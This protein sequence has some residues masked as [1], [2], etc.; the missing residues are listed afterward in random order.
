MKLKIILIVIIGLLIL[1]GFAHKGEKHAISDSQQMRDVI[2]TCLSQSEERETCYIKVCKN[3]S[4]LCAEEILDAIV[5]INGPEKAIVVLQDIMASSLFE[6]KTD[7]HQLAHTIG[8]SASHH[9][10]A[11][12]KS[13]LRC[14][15]DFNYGCQHGFFEK[16]LAKHNEPAKAAES[17]C[18]SLP[19]TPLKDRFYCYHGVG[20]GYMFYVSYN[21][22]KALNLCDTLST[23]T[24]QEGCWQGVFMENVNGKFSGESDALLGFKK[25]DPLAPCNTVDTKYRQQCYEN[26][27]GYLIDYFN[28]SLENATNACLNAGDHTTFCI[29]SIGLMTTNPGWQKVLRGSFEGNFIETAVHICDRFPSEYIQECYWAAVANLANF[30]TLNLERSSEFCTAINMTSECFK[31]VGANVGNLVTDYDEYEKVCNI[32]PD[33]FKDDCLSH[34][35][36]EVLDMDNHLETEDVEIQDKNN[37]TY[38]NQQKETGLIFFIRDSMRKIWILIRASFELILDGFSGSDL[39]EEKTI[40]TP[41]KTLKSEEDS[42]QLLYDNAVI[43]KITIDTPNKILKPEEDS[44]KLLYNDEVMDEMI[45]TYNLRSLT[46]SLSRLGYANGI[47]CHNRA[48]ELGRRGYE[49]LGST[50]FKSC[51]VECHSGC[52]H[53]A[54]EA[55]FADKGTD[56]LLNSIK[57]LCREEKETFGLHQCLHGTGHGL[58]AWFDYDIHGALN[59]CDLIEQKQHRNSCYSGVFMENI[60][61]GLASSDTENEEQHI[62]EYLNDDPHYPCTILDDKYKNTCYFL[63]TDRM[64]TLLRSPRHIGDECAKIPEQ[65]QHSCFGSMGRTISG[66]VLQ[67]PVQSFEL[68]GTIQD[69]KNRNICLSGVLADL[70]WDQTHAERAIAFCKLDHHSSFRVQCYD[71]LINIAAQVIPPEGMDDFC[72]KLPKQ[73][74]DRCN[75]QKPS[76]ALPLS[77]S[78]ETGVANDVQKTDNGVIRYVNS[79]Y[80][81]NTVHISIGQKVTWVNDDQAF[82]PASNLH[83]THTAYPGSN[84]VKCFTSEKDTIFDACEAKGMGE[85][86]SFVF[87]TPGSWRF[88]DHIN[89]QATGTVI[90]SE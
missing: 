79:E 57:L 63:Q 36:K 28:Y 72:N 30:D 66:S 74:N 5:S 27:A 14:P 64:L 29:R 22:T 20:H 35:S 4:Y 69:I 90:V 56:N 67:D 75:T 58:M 49:L 81:P 46:Q 61:G 50:A 18:E 48:H 32:V 1:D 15:A 87:N 86:Y 84:I 9:L 25:D 10:G 44:E 53:G 8:R 60:V 13:F 89:P 2:K 33:E 77:I 16:A 47:D 51:G 24:A 41:N 85:T 12:G 19:S 43:D 26:H 17:I 55:F 6:I 40:D 78:N 62:T 34:S 42:E 37:H 11:T 31:W 39:I 21:L 83:P 65:F 82:W 80:V 7:G 71:Q 38:I 59:A 54:T 88:H 73:H 52:R 3:E 70:I 23:P 68:C 45:K 76:W